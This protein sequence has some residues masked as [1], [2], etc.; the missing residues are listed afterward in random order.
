MRELVRSVLRSWPVEIH[1]GNVREQMALL[2]KTLAR[3][4]HGST[5]K[6]DGMQKGSKTQ[7]IQVAGIKRDSKV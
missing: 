4:A 1:R 5:A 2:G 7:T 3:A 6:T